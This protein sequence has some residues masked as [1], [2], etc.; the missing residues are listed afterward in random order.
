MFEGEDDIKEL[1][2]VDIIVKLK[3]KIFEDKEGY[4]EFLKKSCHLSKGKY[5][6]DINIPKSTFNTESHF[7]RNKFNFKVSYIVI[8]H[9]NILTHMRI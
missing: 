8:C 7:Q 1:L 5:W 4:Q 3:K 2:Q 9:S 6:N